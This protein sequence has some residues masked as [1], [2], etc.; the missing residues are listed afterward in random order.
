MNKSHSNEKTH[1]A[2]G[3]YIIAFQSLEHELIGIFSCLNDKANPKV[4]VIIASKLQFNTLLD[5]LD[6]LFRFRVN[7]KD[8][9][10]QLS[11]IISKSDSFRKERNTYIHSYYDPNFIGKDEISFSRVDKKI[12]RGKGYVPLVRD[13]NPDE[14]K[15]STENLFGLLNYILRFAEN[16]QKKGY[17]TDVYNQWE[18]Y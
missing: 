5:V 10:E 12:H 11:Y 14:L 3:E 9:I 7:D 18:L 2:I 15:S 8:L 6:A 1:A 13:Y 4:G 16:L 17:I